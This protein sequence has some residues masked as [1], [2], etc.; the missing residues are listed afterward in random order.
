MS[1]DI[2]NVSS[3]CVGINQKIIGSAFNVCIEEFH[4]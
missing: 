1:A 4:T 2:V 3:M